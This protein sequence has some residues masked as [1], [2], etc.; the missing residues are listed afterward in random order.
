MK[1]TILTL[2]TSLC[3]LG[4]FALQAQ[5]DFTEE[6]AAN[7]EIYV[8]FDK[9][10]YLSGE[11]L[12][13]SL[14][15]ITAEGHRLI[16]GRRF[17]ELALIDRNKQIVLKERIK[18]VDG[19]SAGQLLLP[20]Y[21]ATGKY[22]MV[23]SY[24]FEDVEQF[25]Y[26]KVIPIY[27]SQS[28]QSA[29]PVASRSVKPQKVDIDEQDSEYLTLVTDKRNYGHRERVLVNLNLKGFDQASLSVVVREKAMGAQN[30]R[31]I[32]LLT[33]DPNNPSVFTALSP[34]ELTNY[35]EKK[36][37]QWKL[38]SSHGLL[39]YEL[40]QKDSL[41]E[42]SIPY[43]FVPQDQ[44][45]LS[46]FEVRPGQFV[47]DGT[48]LPGDAK[49]FFFNNF[50]FNKRLIN[51]MTHWTERDMADNM[52]DMNFGWIVR[53]RNYGKVITAEL[54]DT[55]LISTY[56]ADYAHR[57]RIR[58]DIYGSNAFVRVPEVGKDLVTN[59]MMYEPIDF[60]KLADYSDMVSVPEFLKEVSGGMKVWDNPRRRDLRLA[61]SG[62]RYNSPPLFLVNGVPTND[63]ERAFEIP[64]ESIE[65]IGVIKDPQNRT[66]RDQV[67][68]VAQFGYFG[69]NG[70]IVIHLKEGA[71]NPFEKDFNDLLNTKLYIEPQPYPVPDY[72]RNTLKS[73]SPD[74]RPVLHWEPMLKANRGRASFDFYTSDD[75]GLYEIIVE[76][77]GQNG[78]VI[79][80]R[81]T[82][83]LGNQ[84]L[85]EQE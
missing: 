62:G 14:F 65:G 31:N 5:Q 85:F 63:I 23:L 71:K 70:I 81:Q 27:N 59:R 39:L 55:P 77:I 69:S 60:K 42:N 21:L 75:V 72:N 78:E 35:R 12:W 33:L 64:M 6:Q 40:L 53:P 2:V 50:T 37:L 56:I 17:M 57:N 73:P 4:T 30:N 61:Y 36:P 16:F 45:A 44:V 19:R 28:V 38:L 74:F 10:F 9:P 52:G 68:E 34:S 25:L 43:A 11:T 67:K 47:L 8:Q 24:P 18:V 83:S 13:Y 66:Q 20:A 3:L 79:Y 80:A 46:I 76:G 58:Q 26:R 41:Q 82:I 7:Q 84:K 15:N 29:N 51:N 22:M 48:E 49:S 32:N 1:K 54:N